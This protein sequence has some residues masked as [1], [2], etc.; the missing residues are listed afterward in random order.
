MY[1]SN[2]ND[3]YD[4]CIENLEKVTKEEELYSL[5]ANLSMC[6]IENIKD[7]YRI[8]SNLDTKYQKLFENIWC[9]N[10]EDRKNLINGLKVLYNVE[11]TKT[12]KGLG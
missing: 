9:G 2:D 7:V 1:V 11:K 3:L 4:G 8:V 10:S 5:V 12:C 6:K